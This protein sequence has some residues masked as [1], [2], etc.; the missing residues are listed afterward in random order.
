M[1][2]RRQD[3]IDDL[4]D[5]Y[6]AY[7]DITRYPNADVPVVALCEFYENSEKYVISSKAQLWSAHC[8]EFMY[9]FDVNKLDLDMFEQC[10]QYA[11][12]DGMKRARIGKGHMYTYITPIFI[13]NECDE[14]ALH[15]IKKC[16]IYE[17]FR[18][19]LHG[20]MDFHV[21]VMEVKKDRITTNR[22]G[23]C[24]AKILKNVIYKEKRRIAL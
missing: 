4:L 23:K 8:E 10:K 6:E 12:E 9:L 24:V 20:W 22:N 16:R 21:A 17:S 7:F 1:E 2:D 19:S 13:C 15:A 3:I 5:S 14:Q 11:Y 18:F